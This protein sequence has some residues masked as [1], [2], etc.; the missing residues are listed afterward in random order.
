MQTTTEVG[1]NDLC[2]CGSGQKF[3]KCC[4]Q[5][6]SDRRRSSLPLIAGTALVVAAGIA[7]FIFRAAASEPVTPTST[8]RSAASAPGT[9]PAGKVWSA[10]HKHW[11]DA[12]AP[13]TPAPAATPIQV[14]GMTPAMTPVPSAAAPAG[15]SGDGK[16]WSQEHNHWHNAAGKAIPPAAPVK[17]ERV[18][19]PAAPAVAANGI[20]QPT[21]VA[22]PGKTW[23]AEHGHWH[24]LPTEAQPVSNI[25]VFPKGGPP[26]YPAPDGPA[27]AGKVW[28]ADHG[29][30][31]DKDATTPQR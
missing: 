29:H 24:D 1:R 8:N 4:E 6:I 18:A 14:T 31:H 27:P 28:S 17:I 19:P 10:E 2:P 3:K 30:W 20:P 23:S 22:P 25:R 26:K 11:H 5:K 16:V 21:A 12:A 7:V 15:K 9:A 13:A